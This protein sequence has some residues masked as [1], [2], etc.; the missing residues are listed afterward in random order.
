VSW[1]GGVFASG[2]LPASHH[3][4][5]EARRAVSDAEGWEPVAQGAAYGS[6]LRLYAA[7]GVPSIQL[8]PGSVASAHTVD[9]SVPLG[10]IVAFARVYAVLALRLCG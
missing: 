1:P 4:L 2:R 8:G 7:A 10:E 9:E 3:L 5:H 6:D